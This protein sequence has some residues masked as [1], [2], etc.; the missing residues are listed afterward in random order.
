V[1][2]P[3]AVVAS[4]LRT[5]GRTADEW[6]LAWR[7]G[8][9]EALAFERT[10]PEVAALV[11]YEDLYLTPG[12]TLTALFQRLSLDPGG[13]DYQAAARLPVRGSS[14]LGGDERRISWEPK[15]RS[16]DFRPLARG[17]ELSPAA[18]A[19]ARRARD[20]GLRLLAAG[21]HPGTRL[22]ARPAPRRGRAAPRSYRGSAG[23][24]AGA[25]VAGG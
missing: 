20:A 3:H 14:Q 12:P 21:R 16:G 10:H 18:A 11:R 6:V 9:R 22:A 25:A 7:A 15:P 13:Y 2:D 4:A 17:D 19:L 1:R 23:E 8:A 24:R 5:F